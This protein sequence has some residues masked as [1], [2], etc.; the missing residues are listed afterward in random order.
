[1]AF[2]RV[3]FYYDNAPFVSAIYNVDD[4]SYQVIDTFD[5]DT[6][7]RT[8]YDAYHWFWLSIAQDDGLKMEKAQEQLEQVN[9]SKVEDPVLQVSLA[10]LKMRIALINKN[11]LT[12][13]QS[14]LII[15]RYF[16]QA[17]QK[18]RPYDYFLRGMYHYFVAYGR[19]HSL[20][21][22]MYLLSW[23]KSDGALGL[24]YLQEAARSASCM[25]ATE[26]QY[27]L[28]RIFLDYEQN[29]QQAA[30][31]FQILNK[32]YPNNPIYQDFLTQCK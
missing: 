3:P 23:P 14:Q 8:L 30:I 13:A 29:K 21:F 19:E 5:I 25:I 18:D 28:G 7:V 24:N 20:F 12:A 22:R 10:L 32:K 31:F 11:Y 27:F 4:D 16:A 9:L 2:A 6:D 1:M 26:S 15:R 17:E